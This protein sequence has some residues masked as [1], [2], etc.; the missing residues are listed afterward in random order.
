M[1]WEQGPIRPP[2]EAGSLLLRVTRNCPW[3]RCTFC[4]TYKGKRFSRREPQEILAE[5]RAIRQAADHIRELAGPKVTDG[6][7]QELYQRHGF[8]FFYLANW[9]K[10][11]GR[12]VFIQDADSLALRTEEL[13]TILRALKDAFPTVER[14]T[15]YARA[16]TL[17]RKKEQELVELAG[18][19]LT[20]L[21]VGLESGSDA[22]LGFVQKGVTAREEIEAGRK[23]VAAGISLCFYVLV[24]LGGQNF[25]DG[26]PR[27]TARVIN[28]VRPPYVRLRSLFVK[29]G[30]PLHQ[31]MVEGT[32]TPLAEDEQVEEI[33]S[34]L[35]GI[36]PYQG[37]LVSDHILN[38][39]AEVEGDLSRDRERMLAV[40]RRYLALPPYER[41]LFRLGR[42]M[43][44]FEKLDD[45][46]GPGRGAVEQT[47]S[48]IGGP[49]RVE[50][51][52][53]RLKQH[54]L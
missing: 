47:M 50:A 11:G 48:A 6:L 13:T 45:L 10:N 25:R 40:C 9:L 30:T 7:I 35:E 31:Q 29:P 36:E 51:A 19:G 4:A 23:V 3:N 26:H 14:I 22:V 42:R 21:H 1:V 12:N 18:A 8:E 52:V 49:D 43:G 28:A 39:L 24:G 32:F 17:A 53:E 44:R 15:S 33:M 20:R 41:L 37:R 2:S 34:L 46:D 16:A 27:E 5:I 38:L 54:F